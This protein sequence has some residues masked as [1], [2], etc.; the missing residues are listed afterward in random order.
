MDFSLTPA[1]NCQS[2][3]QP[4]EFKKIFKLLF[5]LFVIFLM[6][7]SEYFINNFIRNIDGAVQLSNSQTTFKGTIIQGIILVGIYGLANMLISNDY[8]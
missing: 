6:V 2:K 1:K 3:R 8:I 5:I 7:T 4:S